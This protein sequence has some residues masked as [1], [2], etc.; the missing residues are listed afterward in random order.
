MPIDDGI[1]GLHLSLGSGLGGAILEAMRTSSSI[2][3]CSNTFGRFPREQE[4][5]RG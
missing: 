5:S 2:F 1:A 3:V 4:A